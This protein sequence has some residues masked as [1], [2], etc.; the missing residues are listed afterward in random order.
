MQHIVKASVCAFTVAFALVLGTGRADAAAIVYEHAPG[1]GGAWASQ[2]TAD[3]GPIWRTFDQFTL[4]GAHVLSGVRWRGAYIDITGGSA[5]SPESTAFTFRFY[6][7]DGGVPAV[8]PLYEQSVAFGN[9]T[10]TFVSA[11]TIA[12]LQGRAYDFAAA[13]PVGFSAS[14]GTPYWLSISSVESAWLPT[15]FAWL[16]GTGGDASTYQLLNLT[17]PFTR[18]GD[19]AFALRAVPEPVSLSLLSAGLAAALFGRRR[20]LR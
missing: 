13:F 14:A 1:G 3:M 9:V 11:I 15:S 4:A 7:D 12:G 2:D 20:R 10:P 6:A 19:R 8:A 16:G 18:S 17:T 5:T